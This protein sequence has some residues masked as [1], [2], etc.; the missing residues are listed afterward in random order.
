MWK[1]LIG[2]TGKRGVTSLL[3]TA[4]LSAT[5]GFLFG[6]G[7]RETPLLGSAALCAE[8]GTCCGCDPACK[9]TCYPDGCSSSTCATPNAWWDDGDCTQNE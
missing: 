6:P 9:K 7:S 5:A 4:L 8:G 1:S 3:P 2:K